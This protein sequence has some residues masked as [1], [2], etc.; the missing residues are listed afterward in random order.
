MF[1]ILNLLFFNY[2]FLGVG[3]KIN[4]GLHLCYNYIIVLGYGVF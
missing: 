1:T 4:Y 2:G 3:K